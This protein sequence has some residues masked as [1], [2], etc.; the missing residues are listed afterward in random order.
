M[1]KKKT[2]LESA[3]QK[4]E[5]KEE[6]QLSE[7]TLILARAYLELEELAAVCKSYSPEIKITIVPK[8]EE[9]KTKNFDDYLATRMSEAKIADLKEKAHKE[10]ERLRGN[11]ETK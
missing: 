2:K 4:L 8:S 10:A 3:L 1:T 7:F 6:L 11:D 9:S 5:N